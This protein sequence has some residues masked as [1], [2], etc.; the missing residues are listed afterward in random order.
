MP[1][2]RLSTN[3][4]RST[5]SLFRCVQALCTHQTDRTTEGQTDGEN[6]VGWVCLTE[7]LRFVKDREG[8]E[9]AET[10]TGIEGGAGSIA[11]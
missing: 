7:T 5:I 6:E 3:L 10:V 11:G 8:G 2:R 9:G 4:R 1:S